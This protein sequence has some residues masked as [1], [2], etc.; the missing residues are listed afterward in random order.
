MLYS[1]EE[2]EKRL[3]TKHRI[4]MEKHDHKKKMHNLKRAGGLSFS[5]LMTILV[6]LSFII[7]CTYAMGAMIIVKDL[8]A[9][10]TLIQCIAGACISAIIGYTCKAGKENTKDGITY[11][12]AMKGNDQY[13]TETNFTNK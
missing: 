4:Q 11:D 3:K 2:K 10:T 1:L 12:T 7:I 8:S 9:L 5:K 13:G 6:V